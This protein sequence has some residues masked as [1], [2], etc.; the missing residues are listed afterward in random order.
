MRGK[1]LDN[2][3]AWTHAQRSTNYY[4]PPP[5]LAL[6]LFNLWRRA[7]PVVAAFLTLIWIGLLIGFGLA[8]F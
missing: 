2:P 7:S 3:R 1:F 5:S 6:R 4:A 8:G